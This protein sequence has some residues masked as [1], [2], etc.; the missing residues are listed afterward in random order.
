MSI[1]N[2]TSTS[3]PAITAIRITAHIITSAAVPPGAWSTRLA[4]FYRRTSPGKIPK[5]ADRRWTSF[6]CAELCLKIACAPQAA[7]LTAPAR[8]LAFRTLSA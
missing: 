1:G 6:G 2:V 4:S 7:A 5:S 3:S 8:R